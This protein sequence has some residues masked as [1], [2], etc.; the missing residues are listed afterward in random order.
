MKKIT[1]PLI[2]ITLIIVGFLI[3]NST[4][5]TEPNQTSTDLTTT[6][7]TTPNRPAEVNGVV[8][9]IEGNEVVIANEIRDRNFTEEELAACK[10]ERQAMS[11]EERR[12]LREEELANLKT[13]IV[14]LIIPVG[15][16]ILKG[17]GDATGSNLTATLEEIKPGVYLSIWLDANQQVEMVKIK[18]IN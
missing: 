16:P 1:L 10:A 18:G 4:N 11:P 2:I 13:E 14:N 3:Y 6:T 12:A 8:K 17:S 15:T 7:L 5:K 9:S